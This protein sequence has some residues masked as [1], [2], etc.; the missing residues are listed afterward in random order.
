MRCCGHACANQ[1]RGAQDLEVLRHG[2]RADREPARDLA[3]AQRAAHE[4]LDDT[5]AG[6]IGEG[7]EAEHAPKIS[8]QAYL[9]QY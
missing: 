4:H 3:D 8:A 9:R 6:R 7:R 5:S 1:L 2:R